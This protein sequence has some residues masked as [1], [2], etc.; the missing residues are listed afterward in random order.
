MIRY[1]KCK[2]QQPYNEG[3]KYC[4]KCGTKHKFREAKI[5]RIFGSKENQFDAQITLKELKKALEEA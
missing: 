3:D 5:I 2:K 4:P 1:C